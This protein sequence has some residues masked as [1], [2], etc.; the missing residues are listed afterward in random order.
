MPVVTI[1]SLSIA[2]GRKKRLKIEPTCSLDLSKTSLINI[3]FPLTNQCHEILSVV[4]YSGKG[5]R[6]CPSM[7]GSPSLRCLTEVLLSIKNGNVGFRSQTGLGRY[8]LATRPLHSFRTVQIFHPFANTS[9]RSRSI[10]IIL[11]TN[12]RLRQLVNPYPPSLSSLCA[13]RHLEF[14]YISHAPCCISNSKS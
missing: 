7:L 12:S 11:S 5:A 4:T 8:E 9:M 3:I 2:R 6:C 10:S 1:Q 13:M 14:E